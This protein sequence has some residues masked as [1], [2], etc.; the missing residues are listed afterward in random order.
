MNATVPL[1]S[2]KLSSG[3]MLLQKPPPPNH[4]KPAGESTTASLATRLL[5]EIVKAMCGAV[6]F[7]PVMHRNPNI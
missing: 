6:A 7:L 3:G 4:T 5:V 1:S 2:S